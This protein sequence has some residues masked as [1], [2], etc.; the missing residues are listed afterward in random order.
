M[1]KFWASGLYSLQLILLTLLLTYCEK[2][3]NQRYIKEKKGKD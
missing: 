1:T 3:V 2:C